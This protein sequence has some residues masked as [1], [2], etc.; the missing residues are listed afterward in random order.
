MSAGSHA[1]CHL[2]RRRGVAG[3]CAHRTGLD[4]HLAN[5]PISRVSDVKIA[6]TISGNPICGGETSHDRGAIGIP[7]LSWFTR[8]RAHLPSRN[9]DL[10]NC[11][12]VGVRHVEIAC[13]WAIPRSFYS[14]RIAR[15]PISKATA[16]KDSEEK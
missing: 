10:P 5:A 1:V 7:S 11:K 15:D 14:R 2:I 9:D 4:D 3:Q 8:K 13:T 16:R 12:V 6:R